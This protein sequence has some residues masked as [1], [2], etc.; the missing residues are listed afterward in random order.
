M[1]RRCLPGTRAF[2]SRLLKP[3]LIIISVAAQID[4][5]AAEPSS[6]ERIP[7]L[8]WAGPPQAE[9][10]AER[11]RE[12]SDA[13]FTH[14]YSSFSNADLMEKAL[15]VAQAAGIRQFI[16]IPELESAPE[17]IAERFKAHPA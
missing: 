16:N 5:L 9:T 13:G 17:K 14:N 2:L 10:N 4:A 8:A 12:L 3:T 1:M 7:V 6:A 15:N 11:Y